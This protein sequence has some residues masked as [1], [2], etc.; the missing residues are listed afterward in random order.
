M[1][2]GS[3]SVRGVKSGQG[4]WSVSVLHK[5]SNRRGEVEAESGGWALDQNRYG[6]EEKG[7][8]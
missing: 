4:R 3:E 7:V 1:D 6:I 2:G 8:G 5:S